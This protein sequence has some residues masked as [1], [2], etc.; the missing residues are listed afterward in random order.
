MALTAAL[1]QAADLP[2]L[3]EQVSLEVL[4]PLAYGLAQEVYPDLLEKAGYTV[5][6]TR[7][8]WG[9]GNFQAGGMDRHQS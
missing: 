7:K 6:F 5:G 8:G 3:T 9:P 2:L 1:A 4:L